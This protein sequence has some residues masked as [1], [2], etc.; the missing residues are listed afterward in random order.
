[1]TGALAFVIVG[2]PRSGTTLV[3]RLSEQLPG[4]RTPPETQFLSRV[5]YGALRP[6]DFPLA[7]NELRRALEE[8]AAFHRAAEI[9]VDVDAIVALLDGRA[10]TVVD[11]FEAI[12]AIM[13]GPAPC[14]GEKTPE[15]LWWWRVLTEARPA[16][17]VVAVER[18][19]RAVV[20]SNLAMPFGMRH[21]ELLAERWAA[22]QQLV[23]AAAASLDRERFLALRYED[24]VRDVD[25]ARAAL[26]TLLGTADASEIGQGGTRAV[27]RAPGEHWKDRTDGD[28]DSTRVDAWRDVLDDAQIA[29]VEAR[30]A[31]GMAALRYEPGG[32]P[33]VRTSLA[34]RVR[35]ARFRRARAQRIA[36]I[37]DF[38]VTPLLPDAGSAG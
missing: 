25:E 11:L 24:V 19:P 36:G 3:Q 15:H 21:V 29:C 8:F 22:D 2:T 30:C 17:K 20:A 38:R 14:R 5:A 6:T 34:A 27:P 13:A 35:V 28:I 10:A 26:A 31:D 9:T 16:L 7:G 18:D 37:D 33:R 1:V 32:A 23:R 12:V 4:V